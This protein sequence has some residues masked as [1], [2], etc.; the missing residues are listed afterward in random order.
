MGW[1]TKVRGSPREMIRESRRCCSMVGPRTMS[2]IDVPRDRIVKAGEVNL[3][4]RIA[5]EGDRGADRSK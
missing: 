2:R 4:A 1:V 5:F 3:I